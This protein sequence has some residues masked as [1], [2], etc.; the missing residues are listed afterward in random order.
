MIACLCRGVSD[1]AVRA[2]IA[3]GA[4]TVSDIRRACGAGDD[5]GSCC[6]TLAAMV[7]Q[8]ERPPFQ[9]NVT[10]QYALAAEER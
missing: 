10:S 2:A 4:R 7:R 8:A 6:V 9:D 5:C 1:S 3:R